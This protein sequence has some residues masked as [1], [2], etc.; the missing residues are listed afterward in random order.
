MQ[1][2]ISST[3]VILEFMVFICSIISIRS[4]PALTHFCAGRWLDIWQWKSS[5]PVFWLWVALWDISR[6]VLI[7]SFE[8]G[9]LGGQWKKPPMGSHC[10]TGAWP[11]RPTVRIALY[12]SVPM[13]MSYTQWHVRGNLRYD[14]DT[15][16]ELISWLSMLH[17]NCTEREFLLV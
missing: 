8:I 7:Y 9:T 6:N 3:A 15:L 16:H 17:Y 14:W 11:T 13:G 12:T 2:I 1:H 10:E 4:L 5:V